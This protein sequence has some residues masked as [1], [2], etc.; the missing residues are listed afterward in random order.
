MKSTETCRPRKWLPTRHSPQLLGYL[1]LH[2]AVILPNRDAGLSARLE[3][4]LAKPTQVGPQSSRLLKGL[5]A[6]SFAA[7]SSPES[8][9]RRRVGPTLRWPRCICVGRTEARSSGWFF[10][11]CRTRSS[12]RARRPWSRGAPTRP[13]SSPQCPLSVPAS[14]Q[15]PR[16]IVGFEQLGA[17]KSAG[18][19]WH[20]S[21][22]L[23]PLT[24]AISAP[25]A[26]S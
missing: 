26:G 1:P 25:L 20:A 22:P 6:A 19:P 2:A 14:G 24:M 21:T 10:C 7:R 17:G 8:A 12:S 3:G 18:P 15:V 4:T 23:L 5:R 13:L 9:A 11:V 16:V